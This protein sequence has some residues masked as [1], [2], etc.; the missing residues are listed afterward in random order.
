MDEI[1]LISAGLG[2]LVGLVL[3]LTGA[4]GTILAI[5]LL[6]FSLGLS[7]QQAAPVALMAILV[8]STIGAL[9][10]LRSNLVRY[11]AAMLIAVLGIV[12]APVGVYA[13]HWLPGP[14]LNG[15]FSGILIAVA[16]NSW[17]N[18]HIADKSNSNAPAPACAI[19]P[20][21][22]RLFWTAPCTRSLIATGGLAGFL[23]GLLGVGGGFVVVPSLQRVSN[24]SQQTIIATT[25]AA[26][27]LISVS[28]LIAYSASAPI[29]WRIALPFML[30]TTSVMIVLSSFRDKIPNAWSQ[31]GFAVLCL[32]AAIYLSIN[33]VQA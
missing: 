30:S 29:E 20:A 5:P 2:L 19:N 10:G 11:K 27:A 7:V 6:V 18:A 16:F 25:L 14:M 4:G 17:K 13:A 22:S 12:C 32:L 24:F 23:S 8:A 1:T 15:L 26:I 28:S 21:T 31:K 3:A 9:Q 33:A